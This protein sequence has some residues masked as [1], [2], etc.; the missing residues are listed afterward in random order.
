M[1]IPGF[2]TPQG[3]A[4]HADQADVAPG[5]YRPDYQSLSLSSLGMGSYLGLP[6]SETSKR[7]TEAAINSVQSGAIN[8]LDTAINYRYQ[9]AERSI[10]EALSHLIGDG[11]IQRDGL[12]VASKVGYLSPDADDPRPAPVYFRQE[13]INTG[14]LPPDQVSQGCHSIHP[15]YLAH[16]VNK[17]LANLGLE[18]LDLLYL[19]NVAE[20]QLPDIKPT[21]LLT[22]L[23]AAFDQLEQLRQQGK[24]RFY[25]L[26]TWDCFR[27]PPGDDHYLSLLDVFR[28]AESIGGSQHG[29]RYI[30]LPFNLAM[31]EA[32]TEAFQQDSLKSQRRYP[33][34]RVAEALNVGVFTS[35]P[36]Y[37]GNLLQ[38]DGLPQ[39]PDLSTPAQ[40]CLQ[41]VRCTP[42]ILA[43]LV[44]HKQP[45]HVLQNCLVAK[46]PILQVAG[47]PCH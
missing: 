7:V 3:T 39:F 28:L 46:T 34:L 24:L 31:G 36:L 27:V 44:G 23:E 25:G 43:P 2:A 33:I 22:R 14:I 42:G 9:L 21:Q 35:V 10:G 30:Q 41:A 20:S 4:R 19:H 40:Q 8:V 5:H 12:F 26:A 15:A 38:T 47:S 1:S 18:T 17:S 29:L 6:D 45:Q 37:Q 13:L 16:Q 11:Q 32:A